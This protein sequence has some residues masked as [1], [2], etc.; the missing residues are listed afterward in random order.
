MISGRL[1][2]TRADRAGLVE[3][4]VEVFFDQLVPVDPMPATVRRVDEA[5]AASDARPA[6][7]AGRK[8]LKRVVAAAPAAPTTVVVPARTSAI[9]DKQGRFEVVLPDKAEIAS[10]KLRFVVSAP[11]G[12]TIA[13]DA[14][15]VS[16]IDGI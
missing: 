12:H 5:L 16:R 7:N 10:K 9:T 3:C 11:A 1:D 15:D 8:S 13:D 6:R 14:Q 4:R 2:S